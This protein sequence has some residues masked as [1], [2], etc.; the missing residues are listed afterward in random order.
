MVGLWW[1]ES[2]I[3]HAQEAI[4]RFGLR[5]SRPENCT[6]DGQIQA[7]DSGLRYGI[8]A[9]GIYEFGSAISFQSRDNSSLLYFYCSPAVN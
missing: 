7:D 6:L 5:L 3:F 8:N 4:T 1:P 9:Q 2:I